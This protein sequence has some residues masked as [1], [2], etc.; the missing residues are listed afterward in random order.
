MFGRR[1]LSKHLL[2]WHEE[3]APRLADIPLFDG[4]KPRAFEDI[5][6]HVE[7]ITLPGGRTLMNEG[8]IGDALYFVATGALGVLVSDEDGRQEIL[9][10]ITAG[11]TVGELS[12]ITD[13]P[14]SATLVALRDTELFRIEEDPFND[15]K[16]KHPQIIENL[17]GIVARRLAETTRRE[18]TVHKVKNF[19]IIPAAASVPC[20]DL[21][22]QIEKELKR[23]GSAA[24]LCRDEQRTESSD[25]FRRIEKNHDFVLYHAHPRADAWTTPVPSTS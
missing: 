12:L 4:L 11:G 9:T 19:C 17:L 15:L 2:P 13:E 3:I 10:K 22:N 21:V 20:T 25:W 24:Y 1:K 6:P 18:D 8:E 7:W 5:T 16:K 14:R 23:R